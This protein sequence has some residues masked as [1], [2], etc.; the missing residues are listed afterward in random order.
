MVLK[1][2]RHYSQH[3]ARK[4]R[5]QFVRLAF[6]P[7]PADYDEE[8]KR[9]SANK[10][11]ANK[12]QLATKANTRTDKTNTELH[13]FQIQ[14]QNK[15]AALGCHNPCERL[16]KP[17]SH[18]IRKSARELSCTGSASYKSRWHPPPSR[19]PRC[20]TPSCGLK[21]GNQEPIKIMLA[22]NT[23][24]PL[25]APTHASWSARLP[26][27]GGIDALFRTRPPWPR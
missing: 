19:P 10:R 17:L 3:K 1:I 5:Q 7:E 27:Y 20:I 11:P 26:I 6:L 12:Y 23:G 9:C 4:Q 21:A 22:F 15:V 13:E 2:C 25:P 8:A 14:C 16:R 18:D 24:T